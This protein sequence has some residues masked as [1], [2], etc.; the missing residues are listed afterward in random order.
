MN[1]ANFLS[2]TIL[3]LTFQNQTAFSQKEKHNFK[4]I[5]LTKIANFNATGDSKTVEYDQDSADHLFVSFYSNNDN[6]LSKTQF[7]FTGK[8]FELISAGEYIVKDELKLDGTHINYREDGKC[9]TEQLYKDGILQQERTFYPDGK[10]QSL[11]SGDGKSKN[12]EYKMWYSNGQSS[13]SGNYKND[14]KDGEFQQFDSN[15]NLLKKGNYLNGKL[16]SGEPVVQDIF[17]TIPDILA[18]YYEGDEALNEYLKLKSAEI[19]GLKNI[20]EKKKIIVKLSVDKTGKEI[21]VIEIS[22][23][24]ADE[25]EFVNRIFKDLRDFIPATVEDTPVDSELKLILVFSN[26]GIKLNS[27]KT[28]DVYFSADQM[29]E[30]PGGISEMRKF[31]ASQIRYPVIAQQKQITGKVLITFVIDE[32]G[33]VTNINVLKGVHPSLDNEAKRVINMMPK[34]EPGRNEGK[35]VKVSYTI[36]IT[37]NSIVSEF[38]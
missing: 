4:I 31:I 16:I 9:A 28:S 38:K 10:R 21:K 27:E 32:R 12:G 7:R 15:G 13:L 33:K 30:F 1:I 36:P 25:T 22:G 11:I 24:S 29:P 2:V 20:T 14:L 3:I 17:Y 8:V 5:G 23:A 18:K 35:A 34:W 37:F 26:E 19:E 6:I